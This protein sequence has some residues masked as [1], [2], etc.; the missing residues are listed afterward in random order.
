MPKDGRIPLVRPSST[1]KLDNGLTADFDRRDITIESAVMP[2]HAELAALAKLEE[3]VPASP[4]P[5]PSLASTSSE[6]APSSAQHLH[7]ASPT[8]GSC[9]SSVTSWLPSPGR[10]FDTTPQA[11]QPSRGMST[12]AEAWHGQ[13]SGIPPRFYKMTYD[14]LVIACGC[15]SASFGIPGVAKY[16]HFLKDIRDAR[17]IRLR[18]L[19]CLE[20][21]SEPGCCPEL[22]RALLSFKVVGGGPTGVEWAAELHDFI[23]KDVYRLYPH[24]RDQ[25]SITLYDVA[26]GILIN[27]DESLRAYAEKKFHRNGVSIKGNSRITAVGEDWI[28]VD[29]KERR[30]RPQFILPNDPGCAD[31]Q[32]LTVCSC[33]R[34]VSLQIH[35]STLC[36][37]ES[38][39][40]PRRESKVVPVTR[41]DQ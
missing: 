12:A 29:G 6:G 21:A 22:R 23:H 1:V 38:T 41:A 7:P 40:V 9:S 25:V 20:Q 14:K 31:W 27:F 26:P 5:T 19:E 8:S 13:E 3:G 11:L 10:L 32:T 15:Y 30:K 18:L 24:L 36:L 2:A 34:L 4:S 39:S 28:E 17:K 33:G 35:L 37:F 16:A